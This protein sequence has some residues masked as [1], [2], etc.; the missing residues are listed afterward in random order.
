VI[1]GTETF[2]GFSD[3]IGA[4]LGALKTFNYQRIY[5]AP[6]TTEQLP[7]IK[8]CYE[9]LFDITCIISA[10]V[11]VIA[12]ASICSPIC[13]PAISPPSPRR[14]GCAISSPA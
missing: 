7:L 2:I 9:D 6:R 12:S 10:A 3:E 11:P 14:R 8:R 13:L 1:S 5:L 4:A